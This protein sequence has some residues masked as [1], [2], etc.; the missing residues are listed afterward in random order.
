MSR[1]D[2][3]IIGGG[4]NG[5]TAA[6]YLGRAG[7][8]VLVLER[9]EIVG[10][11]CVT[12]EVIPDH[13]VSF[14][15]YFASMLMP[16]VIRDLEL[17]KYGLRMVGSDP[18]LAVALA[19]GEII[20]WW[21]DVDRAAAEIARYSAADAKAFVRVD[22]ELK[23]L[24]AYLQP[25]FLEPPPDLG[26]RGL[27][28]VREAARL[29]KRFRKLKGREVAQLVTFLT[30]SLGDYLDRNFESDA[31]KRLFLA[32]N[33]Y[34]KHGGPYEPGSAVGL[35]FHLLSGGDDS[36]QGYAGHVIGG[37]GAITQAIA[38]SAR[39]HGVEIR[40]ASPVRE[41]LVE[42]GRASGVVTEAGETF[43]APVILSNADPKR[44]F[45]GMV[46]PE[47]LPEDFRSDIAA[48]KMAGP[49]AK[50]N[51]AL[52]REPTQFGRNATM[53]PR[54]RSLLTIVPTLEE[55]QRIADT[56]R[57]GTVPDQLWIDCVIPS[58]VDDTLCPPG[59]AVMTCFIQYLPFEL[60]EGSWEDRREALG[61]A[62]VKQIARHMPDLPDLIEGR[63]VLTPLDLE[64]TY[65]LTEGNIFH[66]D[67]NIGQLFSMRPTP[68]WSQY[69]TPLPGLYLC[70]AGAHPGGGV[71]GAPGHNAA[72]QVLRDMRKSKR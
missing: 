70:G 54:E 9:R 14:T 17:P 56:A 10:G 50:L 65:G 34:G 4:H 28:R 67:L 8:K 21:A 7:R 6:A 53:D 69:R 45:L 22:R 37:M 66:G 2:A 24:A 40:T 3:I 49:S 51:L 36:V 19:P 32:N 5:L 27:D 71:T 46:P 42:N 30:G 29:V 68:A 48:I 1:Y 26:A 20:R 61:D 25:F 11:A 35:L 72:H 52:K 60:R 41:I 33:V 16:R 62:I 57:F 59:K 63:V 13:R 38:A 23:A 47:H 31:V 18:L 44:T 15:S 64:R 43:S 55:A 39:D 58:L 12:E